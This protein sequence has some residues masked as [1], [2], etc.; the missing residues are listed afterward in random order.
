MQSLFIRSTTGSAGDC[1][2]THT[3]M[4][5]YDEYVAAVI[6]YI[7]KHGESQKVIDKVMDMLP[8][9]WAASIVADALD[10]I[11]AR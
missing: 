2:T 11:N 10:E 9:V 7:D 1:T 6:K 8:G 4:K 5:T 3:N